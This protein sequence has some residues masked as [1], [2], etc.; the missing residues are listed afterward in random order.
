MSNRN[1]HSRAP[2][3]QNPPRPHPVANILADDGEGERWPWRR[4]ILNFMIVAAGIFLYL[5]ITQPIIQLTQFYYFSDAHSLASAVYAL[6][7]DREFLLAGVILVFSILLPCAKLFYLY[8]LAALSPAQLAAQR[9]VLRTLESV[10]K[11][12]MHDVLVI[13]LTIVYLKSSGLGDAVSQPGA[14]YF[15]ISVLLIMASYGWIKRTARDELARVDREARLAR[16]SA[17]L[18]HDEG[19][20][21]GD[22]SHAPAQG[23]PAARTHRFGLLRRLLTLSVTIAAGVTLYLGLTEPALKLT[24]LYVWSDEQSV[25]A[26]IEALYAQGEQFLAILIGIF[27]VVFPG[28]KLLYLLV[29]TTLSMGAPE[30]HEKVFERLEWLGK[31]SMMDVMVLALIIF[32]VNAGT[33]AQA[34]AQIGIYYFAASVVLTMVAY[35]LVKG[36][37]HRR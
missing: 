12:S 1:S 34:D 10:G 31:W 23:L 5:G 22:A 8:V 20:T 11:W 27:S 18:M 32:Y 2:G 7:L 35:T 13:A 29:V 17:Q 21:D 25:M 36:G 6:Y 3:L 9:H 33:V 15:A 14:R 37:L 28:L 4:I 26:A 16:E 30:R 24:K 19:A